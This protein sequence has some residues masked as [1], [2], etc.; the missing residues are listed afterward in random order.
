MTPKL[1]DDLRQ[2]LTEHGGAPVY[3]VDDATSASYV[4]IRA[5]QYEAMKAAAGDDDPEA[6]YPLLADIEPDDWEDA[7]S[8]GLPTP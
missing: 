6:L 2:A 3:V 7:A 1:N 4:L 8:Y 5:E